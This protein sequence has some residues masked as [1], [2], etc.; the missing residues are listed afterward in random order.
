MAVLLT[1]AV[2]YAS[3]FSGVA[4]VF[5]GLPTLI[6]ANAIAGVLWAVGPKRATPWIAGLLLAPVVV[7]GLWLSADAVALLSG[8]HQEL[9]LGTAY[10]VLLAGLAAGV[11]MLL[12]RGR[13]ESGAATRR[14]ATGR[15][16]ARTRPA[17]RPSG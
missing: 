7:G 14:P 12:R 8:P 6:V 11:V 2:A 5:I 16:R 13:P 15:P 9:P 10:F 3:D 4:T 1:P 17:S